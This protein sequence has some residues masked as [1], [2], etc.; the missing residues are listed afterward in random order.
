MELWCCLFSQVM[1]SLKEGKDIRLGDWKAADVEFLNTFQLLTAKPVVY[2]VSLMFLTLP[3]LAMV[4]IL[5]NLCSGNSNVVFEYNNKNIP[6]IIPHYGLSC[7]YI[8]EPILSQRDWSLMSEKSWW[9][10][11]VIVTLEAIWR[12]IICAVANLALRLSIIIRAP[13]MSSVVAG[14][15]VEIATPTTSSP[16]L[17]CESTRGGDL[18]I[19]KLNCN[20]LTSFSISRLDVITW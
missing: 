16:D 7:S 8:G 14:S 19:F 11:G 5:Q 4:Q 15:R 1:A 9:F 6:S 12:E 3:I 10:D 18:F 2:L 13:I 17:P 20:Q